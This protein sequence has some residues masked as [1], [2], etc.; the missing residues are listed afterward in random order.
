MLLRRIRIMLVCLLLCLC[1]VSA[2]AAVHLNEEKPAG[3]DQ[4]ELLRIT[5]LNFFQNDA[6]LLECGG[7]SMLLDGGAQRH[8]DKLG[9]YLEARDLSHVNIL[10]NTHPHDDH[11]GAVYTLMRMG[12]LTAD[13][14][15]SPFPID[16][17][18]RSREN[19]QPLV[20]ARLEMLGIPYRQMLPD[21]TLELGKT[22]MTLYR[23]DD[24]R[25]DNARSGVLW[26]RFGQ[27]S[28]LLTADIEGDAQRWLLGQ[29]PAYSLKADIL[30]APHH[31]LN[32]IDPEFLDTVEPELVIVNN[33]QNAKVIPQ[34]ENH[35]LPYLYTYRGNTVLETDGKD[36][37]VTQERITRP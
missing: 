16:A 1:A 28:I 33:D 17:H 20:V 24:G 22:R 10:F 26:V 6:Y 13:E 15:I 12:R 36:W 3:W 18:A 8:W 25:D 4:R 30:K 9:N 29:Y 23:W 11:L 34:L 14:F 5:A 35:S 19:L 31:G 21:E 27:T 37:Y 32:Y 2:Q 7:N